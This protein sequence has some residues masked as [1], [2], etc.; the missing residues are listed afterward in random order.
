MQIKYTYSS[1]KVL[2]IAKEQ[3]EKEKYVKIETHHILKG[4]LLVEDSMASKTL[5]EFNLK[6]D[7]IDSENQKIKKYGKY[8]KK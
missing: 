6:I 3:A 4:L 7:N 2:S 8:I 1:K 5:K